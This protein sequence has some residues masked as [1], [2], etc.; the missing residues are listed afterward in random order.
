M[1][2][3]QFFLALRYRWFTALS[4]W[5]LTVLVVVLLASLLMPTR[6]RASSELLIEE[7]KLDPISGAALAGGSLPNRITTEADVLRS[8]R[9][10]SLA[11]QAMSPQERGKLQERWQS[12]TDGQGDFKAWAVLELQRTTEVRPTRDSRVLS[13]AHSAQDPHFAAA[14]VNALTKAYL[15][16][17]VE[18]RLEPARQYNAFFDERATQLRARLYEAQKRASEFQRRN[19]ITTMDERLDVED[20]RLSELSAQVV[21]LQARAGEAARRR[22]EAAAAPDRME[23]VLKDPSVAALASALSLQQARL[24][25]LMERMGNRHPQVIEARAATAALNDRLDSAR[26]RA[27]AAFEGGSRVLTGQ[28]TERTQALELQ[29]DKVLQR[30]AARDQARLLQNEVD[31]AQR[32]FDALIDRLNKTTLEKSAPQVS[33]SILK[34]ATAPMVPASAAITT[35]LSVGA[36]LGLL[37]ALIA[38]VVAEARDRRLRTADDVSS[39]LEQPVL[40]VLRRRKAQ[41]PPSLMRPLLAQSRPAL[42]RY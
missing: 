42:T 10:V 40:A 22:S 7:E 15:D 18:L 1:S 13:V 41:G 33:V 16:T 14:F 27:A 4:V 8:E 24:T 36:V 38:T 34:A 37:M 20:A 31:V 12:Q 28:L 5:A 32:S 6:Y 39:S 35:N 30:K 29:R 11:L 19:G 3:Q 9:V 25:E 17:S 21:A 23:E 2:L 26:R